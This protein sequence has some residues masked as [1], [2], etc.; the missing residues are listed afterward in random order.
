VRVAGLLPASGLGQAGTAHPRTDDR[1]AGMLTGWERR[2]VVVVALREQ[3]Q[4]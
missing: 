2:G 4:I 3:Y 1:R